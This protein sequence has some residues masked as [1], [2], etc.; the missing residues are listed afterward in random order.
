PLMRF[1]GYYIL[2]DWLEIPNLRDRSNRMLK[3]L[4][5]EYALGMEVQPEPYM[6]TWRKVLFVSYAVGSYIYRWVLTF[7]ILYFLSNWLKPYKL[8]ALSTMLALAALGSLVGWPLYR[9]FKG[10][11]K[12]GRLPDMKR[13]NVS[14]MA[15]VVTALLVGFFFVPLPI[16]R[17]RQVGLVQI[18]PAA[19]HK[20]TLTDDAI[21]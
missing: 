18:D 5:C 3:N 15:V 16:S 13:K 1:D 17:V 14:I 6:E 2:A 4:S 20:V 8:G 9:L 7:S 21:L 19:V 10:L 12:R 11:H